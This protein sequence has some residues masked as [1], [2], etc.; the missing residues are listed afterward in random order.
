MIDDNLFSTIRAMPKIDLHR[1]L[2]GSLRLE[3]LLAIALEYDISLPTFD[4]EGLRPFVQMVP[5]EPHTWQQFLGKFQVLRQFYRSEAIIKRVTREVIADAEADNVKYME[6]RFTPQA[7]NNLVRCDYAEVVEWVCQATAEATADLEIDVM[8]ILSMNRHESVEIGEQVVRA[9]IDYAD[10]GVV[11]IDLAGQEAGH[12]GLPFRDLFARAKAEGLG[13]TIHAGEWAGAENVREAVEALGAD[14]I[15]HGIRL[16]EDPALMDQLQACGT[17][18]EVCPTSN[19]QSGAVADFGAHPLI[20]LYRQGIKTTINT[21]DPL[22]CNVTMSDEIAQVLEHT[23]LTLDD[24]KQQTIDSCASRLFAERP[25]RRAGRAVSELV[26]HMIQLGEFQLH[27]INDCRVMMDA[28]G[29]FGLV[30]R[31]LYRDAFMPPTDDNLLPFMQHNLLVRAHGKNILIDTGYGDKLTE[32]QRGYFHHERPQGGLVASLARLGLTPDD[33]DLVID[34]HLHSDHCAGNTAYA[35]D[36]SVVP[37]FP[38][39]EYVV[40]RREYEDASRPNERTRAT[41]VAA[42]FRPLVES[43]QM[44]LLDGDT[45]FLPGIR[46]VVTPGHTPGHMSVRLESAGS[47]PRSCAIWRASPRIS[48]IWAG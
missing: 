47:T 5:G 18:L 36:G 40:Q 19:V 48:S 26:I 37:V 13:V 45:E 3:T 43:G 39:A 6:L 4:I 38:N 7:L 8:L 23:P 24:I 35:E 9:A 12:S 11:G 33:I 30:P 29:A 2:E 1:H 31:A 22:V 28:G 15:G 44:R 21:D 10:R 25:A 17:V 41:Y 14:R 46:G 27:L 20:P 34:T 16:I 32:K 42:N